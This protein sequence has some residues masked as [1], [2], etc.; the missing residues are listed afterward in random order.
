[1]IKI[2]IRKSWMSSNSH[3]H[4]NSTLIYTMRIESHISLLHNKKL[5]F[6]HSSI[7]TYLSHI[8]LDRMVQILNI[9]YFKNK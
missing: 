7:Y 3:Y 4:L 8:Y 9:I 2:N 6:I 1:M 5:A